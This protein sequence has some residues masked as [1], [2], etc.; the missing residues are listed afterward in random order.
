MKHRKKFAW[1]VVK[2]YG[3][4]QCCCGYRYCLESVV[5]FLMLGNSIFNNNTSEK[6][7]WFIKGLEL[8]EYYYRKSMERK[9]DKSI[10]RIPKYY[11]IKIITY[12]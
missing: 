11:D 10:K 1:K 8:A 9:Y 2:D 5:D 4:Y 12:Y 6:Y 3:W 7:K